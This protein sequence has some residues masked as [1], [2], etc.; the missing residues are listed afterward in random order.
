M[1][2]KNVTFKI[3]GIKPT[4]CFYD[5]KI[6]ITPELFQHKTALQT[7]CFQTTVTNFYF[8]C[9]DLKKHSSVYKNTLKGPIYFRA[10]YCT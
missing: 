10:K 2:I 1:A 5:L 9:Q 7:L 3:R 6:T 4:K 8:Q